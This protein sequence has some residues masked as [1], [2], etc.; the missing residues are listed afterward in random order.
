MLRRGL[1]RDQPLVVA[2]HC[3]TVLMANRT[4]LVIPAESGIQG[5]PKDSCSAGACPGFTLRAATPVHSTPVITS[6]MLGYFPVAPGDG[7]EPSFYTGNLCATS[8]SSCRDTFMA[9]GYLLNSRARSTSR[10]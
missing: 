3:I 4:N 8:R 7:A 9:K 2:D 10:G 6:N 1:L 5:A